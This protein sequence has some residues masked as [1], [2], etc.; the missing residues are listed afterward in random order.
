MILDINNFEMLQISKEF[1][2]LSEKLAQIIHWATNGASSSFL[3]KSR[4]MQHLANTELRVPSANAG[5]MSPEDSTL[6]LAIS[7]QS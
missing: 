6:I 5:W 4:L 1:S 3:K 2:L 7:R